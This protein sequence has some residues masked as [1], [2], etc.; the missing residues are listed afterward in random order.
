M[1]KN[2]PDNTR[3]KEKKNSGLQLH[4]RNHFSDVT[5]LTADRVF[6]V[7][8]PF[9]RDLIT[10]S[11]IYEERKVVVNSLDLSLFFAKVC[12]RLA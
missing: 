2:F 6:H 9:V 10:R 7:L 11:N 12:P 5:F 8:R 1:A 4:M 3:R